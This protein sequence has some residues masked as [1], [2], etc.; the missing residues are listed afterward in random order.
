M[1]EAD[2]I[3]SFAD[4]VDLFHLNSNIFRDQLFSPQFSSSVTK[5]RP[6]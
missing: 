5:V 4:N 1:L 3:T 2:P 6:A